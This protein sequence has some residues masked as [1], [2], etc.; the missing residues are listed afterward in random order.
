MEG[1]V[2]NRLPTY[3]HAMKR[4][5]APGAKISLED[6]YNQYGPKH[7]IEKGQPFVDWLRTVKLKDASRWN[8]VYETNASEQPVKE[9]EVVKE[10]QKPRPVK[11]G[12]LTTPFV[13]TSDSVKTMEVSDIVGLSVRNAR[14]L[15]PKITDLKL[16]KYAFQEANTRTGKD[17]LCIV[18]R[19]RIKE[20]EL[21]RTM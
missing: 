12:D 7:G 2:E 4:A 20:L 17:S 14:E 1:Y 6:I 5:V 13:P 9:K 16:L 19:R 21:H 10:V 18:L 11:E 15:M 3:A 8:I